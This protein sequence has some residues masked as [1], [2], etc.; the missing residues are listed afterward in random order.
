MIDRGFIKWQPFNSVA[1][2]KVIINNIKKTDITNKP[3]LFPEK[4]AIL[5]DLIKDA[6][7]SQNK[8]II[9]YYEQNKIKTLET[10]ITKIDPAFNILELENHKK[11]TFNQ[12]I[13]IN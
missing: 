1:P 7:Y 3:I 10:I 8:I 12:I 2:N 13:N 11:I 9:T 4:I 6:Y 5:N